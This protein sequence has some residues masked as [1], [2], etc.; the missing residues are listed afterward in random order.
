M[1]EL[2]IAHG[3]AQS[4]ALT[5]Y[6]TPPNSNHALRVLALSEHGAPARGA[7]VEL[8]GSERTQ[9]RLIDAGSG[10][11]CQMEPVAHFGLG[12]D[13]TLPTLT[14]TWPGGH[15]WSGLAPALDGT[16]TVSPSGIKDFRPFLR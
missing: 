5:L 3:E 1:L 15:T 13:D 10:Y 11:L 4:E 2:M 12:Q 8:K 7:M 6:V 14:L 16:L 9:V